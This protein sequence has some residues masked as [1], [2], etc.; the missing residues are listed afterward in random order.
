MSKSAPPR[1]GDSARDR[2]TFVHTRGFDAVLFDLDGVLISTAMLHAAASETE[3]ADNPRRREPVSAFPGSIALLREVRDAGLLT[4]VVTSSR[5]ATTV[6]DAVGIVDLFDGVI[7]DDLGVGGDTGPDALLDAA[8]RLAV[9][10]ARTVL[11]GNAEATVAAGRAGGFGLVIGVDRTGHAD[12]L[13]SA[14]ADLVVADL[15]EML[16]CDTAV[17]HP[18]GPKEHRLRA[19]GAR[20]LASEGDFPV[21][22]HRIVERRFDADHVPQLESIFALTNGYL[23]IRGVHD[24]GRPARAPAA[25]LNGFYETW[26]IVYPEGAYG[27]AE[28]GQT[29]VSVPD[30]SVIRLYVNDERFDLRRVEVLDYER[31]LDLAAATLERRVTW[32]AGDGRRFSLH[33]RRL[34]SLERRHLACVEY[35]VTALDGPAQIT[36]SSELA[37]PSDLPGDSADP[38]RSRRFADDLLVPLDH[39]VDGD[40]VVLCLGTRASG[41]RMACGI[42]HELQSGADTE[43]NVDVDIGDGRGAR[44]VYRINAEAGRPVRLVKYLAYH[45]SGTESVDELRFRV[46]ETLNRAAGDG[47]HEI[48]D[49]QRRRTEDFWSTSDIVTDGSLLLQQAVRFNLFELLQAVAQIDGYGL[50]AKGLTGHGYEGH[51]FWDTEIYVLPFLTYTA[52]NRARVL[53][54]HRFDMLQAARRRACEIGNRGAAFPWRTINGEE[55]S[56]HY[57]AGTAQYHLNA[58]IAY[59]LGQYVRVSGDDETMAHFGV[60]LLVETARLWADLGFFSERKRGQFV[61]NGVTGP[62]EYSTVVDNNTYTNLMARENL[63]QAADALDWLAAVDPGTLSRLRASTGLTDDEPASWRRAAD[64]MYIPYD[65]RAA[66]HLQDDG[67]L[68]REVWDFE[69]TP[70]EQYPLLLHFHPLVIYRHQ[71]IKQA[72]VVLA[73]FLLGDAFTTEQKRRILEYYDPL[74]T[75]DSSLSECIQAIMAAEVGDMRAAEEYLMDA[76]T[77]DLADSA[78]NVGDGIHVAAAGGT[79]MALVFGF[80]GLRDRTDEPSFRPKLPMRLTR[81]R[82]PLL[83][84]GSRLIVDLRPGTA[85]YTVVDGP[86]LAIRHCDERLTLEPGQPVD[87]P[88]A[89]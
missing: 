59:A 56:A 8:R 77:I 18:A 3:C 85:T 71:V 50:A 23:G 17:P 45:H 41:L 80:G 33:S 21:D 6:L 54:R 47:V 27:L 78:G 26:P 87:R 63:R 39:G 40:R 11:I 35:E 68:D 34:V 61:I 84:R 83:V 43:P 75:G 14:G 13:T 31:V 1:H 79:W 74:T 42:A 15:A 30:G 72:D 4:A 5:N 65:E 86:A 53:L 20:V 64:L 37:T 10:P 25:S 9:L 19:G 62:D 66:V 55:A 38:R 70:P 73:T 89:Q 48:V 24:E 2:P 49:S 60:E 51:Y 81:L 36:I 67:F 44:V 7:A 28:T 82:F 57:A 69:A 88:L 76:A 12:A 16:T 46:N 22:G 32:R 58:D 52:P 29:I